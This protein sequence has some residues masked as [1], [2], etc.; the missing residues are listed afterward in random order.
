MRSLLD[1]SDRIVALITPTT[2]MGLFLA[3]DIKIQKGEFLVPLD[4]L[5]RTPVTKEELRSSKSLQKTAD[6]QI[7]G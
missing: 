1:M 3:L 2:V 4:T 7:A 6:Q 5:R